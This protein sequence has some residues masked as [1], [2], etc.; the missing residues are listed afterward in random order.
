M[1]LEKQITFSVPLSEKIDKKIQAYLDETEIDPAGVQILVDDRRGIKTA[2]L[3]Y[4]ERNAL[5]EVYEKQGREYT[6]FDRVTFCYVKDLVCNFSDNLDKVVNDFIS[7]ENIAIL[8]ITRYFTAVNQGA[9]IFY[10]NIAEQ[11]E[12]EEGKKE[13]YLKKQEELAQKMAKEAVK[14][15]DL[16]VNDTVEKYSKGFSEASVSM[17]EMIENTRAK[18][19]VEENAKEKVEEIT[20]KPVEEPKKK[21]FGRNK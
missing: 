12:K 19:I 3:T 15:T 10:I 5:K 18:E 6:E 17:D 13:L 20:E 11:K 21:R 9:F 14:T 2:T 1:A 7:N 8:S 4:G 16:E